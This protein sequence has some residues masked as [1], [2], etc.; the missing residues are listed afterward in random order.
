MKVENSV[1]LVTGGASGLGLGTVEMIINGGGKAAILDLPSS[2]GAE[3]AD[4]M[5]DSVIF[6]PCD[7]TDAPIVESSVKAVYDHFK[8]I[9][10]VV[11]CAGMGPSR[12]VLTRSGKMYPLEDFK[13]VV[14]INLFG[15][16]DV[17]RW[18]VFYMSKN[19]PGEDGERGLIV[20]CASIAAFDG[21][22]GQCAYSA[23]KGGITQMTL[24]LARDLE[25]WGIRVMTICPGIMDTGLLAGA[26]DKVREALVNIQVFPKRLGTGEDYGKLVNQFMTN[27]YLNGDVV[28]LD[29][30]ARLG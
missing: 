19:E 15:T 3:I 12:R 2:K 26:D 29:T 17:L 28:R 21:E 25:I 24:P 27:T 7:V 23:A 1:A 5:G 14:D 30:S 10:V 16:F 4:K 13:R 11:N 9:D 6:L 20:N 22:T 8:R 18:G